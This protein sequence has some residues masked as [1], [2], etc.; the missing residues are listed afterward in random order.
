[1]VLPGIFSLGFTTVQ[2]HYSVHHHLGPVELVNLHG[3]GVHL[4]IDVRLCRFLKVMDLIWEVMVMVMPRG[5]RS[6]IIPP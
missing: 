5:G 6:I 1:M 4:F 2:L 3:D